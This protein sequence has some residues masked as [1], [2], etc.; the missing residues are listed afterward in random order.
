MNLYKISQS[1]NN[2]YDTFDSA[3]VCAESEDDAR[4]IN[5]NET[6]TG[7][8]SGFSVWCSSPE[9]VQVELIGKALNNAER[10][11]VLAS[12]NAG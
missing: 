6:W 2:D 11:I 8:F 9:Q 7:G 10:G 12:F 4:L 3:I 5:P 1:E